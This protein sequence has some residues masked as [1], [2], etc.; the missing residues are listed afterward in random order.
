MKRRLWY[1]TAFIAIFAVEVCIA[2]FVDDRFIRPY[3]GD[4]LVTVLL[5]CLSRAVF[6]KMSPALPVFGLSVAVELW[7][8]L[9]LTETLHLNGTMLGIVLGSTA[10]WKDLLCYGLGCLVFLGME[11]FMTRK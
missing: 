9:G 1:F 6:P 8:W 7:Q 5:C 10:D 3:V 11:H 2:L 4:V